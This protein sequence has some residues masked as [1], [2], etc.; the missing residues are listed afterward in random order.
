[1]KTFVASVI[2][3]LVGL[4]I[5][6]YVGYR[7]CDRHA[8]NEAV[9]QMVDGMESQDGADAMMAVNCIRLIES[10]ET[11]KAVQ[12]LSFPIATYYS[13]YALHP[14]TNEERLKIRA[15]IEQLASTNQLIAARLKEASTNYTL[16]TP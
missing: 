10:G 4:A 12:M 15:Q 2:F 1:M 9:Q 8:T 7:Y 14:S 5:G 11:Q 3:L 6:C 16:K 13:A